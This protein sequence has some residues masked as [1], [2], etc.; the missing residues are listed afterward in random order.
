MNDESEENFERNLQKPLFLKLCDKE[1]F[2]GTTNN[3]QTV[4]TLSN[5]RNSSCVQMSK[6]FKHVLSKNI[7]NRTDNLLIYNSAGEVDIA[8]NNASNS[9]PKLSNS[10]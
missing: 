5:S 7:I 2:S 8:S 9:L 3:I 6:H 1:E 4:N 10:P